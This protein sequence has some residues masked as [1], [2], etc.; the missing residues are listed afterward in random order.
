MLRPAPTT[1]KSG[2]RVPPFPQMEW[3]STH[4]RSLKMRLPPAGF[5]GNTPSPCALKA[6]P[7]NSTAPTHSRG[8]GMSLSVP[9]DGRGWGRSVGQIARHADADLVHRLLSPFLEDRKSTRLN[10]SHV[11]ISYA[12]FCL[13]KKKNKYTNTMK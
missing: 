7:L 5:P 8:R 1:A 9:R 6:V 12:V 2:P 4:P 3:H 13:K 11:E 10:S